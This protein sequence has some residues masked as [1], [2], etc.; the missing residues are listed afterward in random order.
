MIWSFRIPKNVPERSHPML[1]ATV[2]EM[3]T[4]SIKFSIFIGKEFTTGNAGRIYCR[5]STSFGEY[6]DIACP[7]HENWVTLIV[8][9]DEY[10]GKFYFG[11]IGRLVITYFKICI[12]FFY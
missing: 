11:A 4:Q 7:T 9:R 3:E 6:I 10:Q 2:A 8:E 5:C 1:I 12:K